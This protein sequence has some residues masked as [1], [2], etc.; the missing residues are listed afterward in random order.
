MSLTGLVAHIQL[1]TDT[2]DIFQYGRF[3]NP[4][5]VGIGVVDII[6]V[7][8]DTAFPMIMSSA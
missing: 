1:E 6:Q 3:G 5:T 7:G 4:C 2:C 8:W